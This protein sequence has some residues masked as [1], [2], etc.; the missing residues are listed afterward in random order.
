MSWTSC[1]MFKMLHHVWSDGLGNMGVVC[2]GWCMTNCT[3]WLFLSE[4]STS[5]LWQS[6]VVFATELHGT[7]PTTVCQ[8]PKFLV[9]GICR[10]AR[11][12]QLSVPWVRRSTSGKH[13]FSVTGA[14]VLNSLQDPIELLTPNNLSGTWRRLCSPD[15]W[16]VGALG[17]LRNQAPQIDVYLLT[18]ESKFIQSNLSVIRNLCSI[19]PSDVSND[20]HHHCSV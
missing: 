9:A 1:S 13:A 19:G 16:S 12:H 6:I 10:S 7:S 8:S 17:M 14:T 11:C 15:I 20:Q 5:L 2:H 3:G 18:V 4:C